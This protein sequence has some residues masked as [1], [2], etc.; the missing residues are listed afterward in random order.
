[1]TTELA[2]VPKGEITTTTPATP[3]SVEGRIEANKRVIGLLAPELQ[4]HHLL[5]LNGQRYMRVAGGIAL[6][7]AL[8]FTISVG[9]VVRSEDADGAWLACKAELKDVS[10]GLVVAEATGY[11][12]FDEQ[13]WATATRAAR[14]SMTQT[15][16]IAKLCRSN[17]GAMYTLL[18]ATKDTPAEE[19][20]AVA[21]ETPAAAPAV[22]AQAPQSPEQARDER[23]SWGVSDTIDAIDEKQGKKGTY[24]RVKPAGDQWMSCFDEATIGAI[25]G[26]FAKGQ[27]IKFLIETHP[28]FGGTIVGSKLDVTAPEEIPF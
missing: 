12:G 7:Q 26:A 13:Q 17:F 27:R 3:L 20:T 2:T 25:R 28:K 24:L 5:E 18:G 11:V 1:M 16:A 8:G 10:S 21:P 4:K 9:D 22:I 19:M 6:A 23:S 14:M 15:R